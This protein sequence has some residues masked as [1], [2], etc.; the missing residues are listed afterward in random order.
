MVSVT[1][2]DVKSLISMCKTVGGKIKVEGDVI[3]CVVENPEEF[4]LG[5]MRDICSQIKGMMRIEDGIASCTISGAEGYI[6]LIPED[7]LMKEE[8]TVEEGVEEK[9]IE[10]KKEK[11]VLVKLTDI[12]K[13]LLSR[14]EVL[15]R[16]IRS[17]Q[18]ELEKINRALET[19]PEG[20]DILSQ[21]SPLVR[22]QVELALEKPELFP[23]VK[24]I[25]TALAQKNPAYRDDAVLIDI[26]S[27]YFGK[28]EK[29]TRA[30]T[31]ISLSEKAERIY[32]YIVSK[33]EETGKPVP[34]REI[35]M[36]AV[37]KAKLYANPE[38]VRRKIEEV[39]VKSGRVKKM[40]TPYGVV[41]VPAEE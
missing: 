38:S 8:E 18:A 23:H 22:D 14:K 35:L 13:E 24:E 2:E 36:W 9:E 32:D 19:L 40:R 31:R 16:K 7:M 21:F 26:L 4:H 33:Y 17:L 5:V 25:I 37:H 27:E 15:E 3:S 39:L 34:A 28:K 11:K 29:K 41:Y 1:E 12:K 20:E 10:K 6:E 30:T